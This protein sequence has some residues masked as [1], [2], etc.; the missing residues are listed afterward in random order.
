MLNHDFAN[1]Q[2]PIKRLSLQLVRGLVVPLEIANIV[3][4]SCTDCARLR[5]GDWFVWFV[6]LKP[7]TRS[8][9]IHT[10]DKI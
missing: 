8:F 3:V 6:V 1:L 9:V 5:L 4:C 2:A 10:G 7:I